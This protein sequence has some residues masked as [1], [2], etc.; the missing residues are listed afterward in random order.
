MKGDTVDHR[1]SPAAMVFY[2]AVRVNRQ[3][4]YGDITLSKTINGG[5]I[6]TCAP[7]T[8]LIDPG[9]LFSHR[10]NV[11]IVDDYVTIA[12]QVTYKITGWDRECNSLIVLLE[13]DHR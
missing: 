7:T 8:G 10:A 1:L 11:E 13:A 3:P 12:G 5:T 6:V 4:L 9:I 2:E